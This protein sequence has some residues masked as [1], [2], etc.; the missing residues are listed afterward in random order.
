MTATL[1][2]ALQL[3]SLEGSPGLLPVKEGTA[4]VSYD[5]WTIIRV[6]DLNMLSDDLTFN[7]AKYSDLNNLIDINYNESYIKLVFSNFK[8]QLEY[9]MNQ[10]INRYK[11][12]VPSYRIKRGILNPIGSLIKIIT[13]NLDSEDAKRYDQLIENIKLKQTAVNKKVTLISEI[14]EGFSNITKAIHRNVIQLDKKLKE[15][16]NDLVNVQ[17]ETNLNF[18]SNLIIDTYSLILHNFQTISVKI[19][20]IETAVAFSK[21]ETLH[22]SIIESDDLLATLENIEKTEKL[23]FKVNQENLVKIEQSI[24]IKAFFKEN[25]LTFLLEIPLITKEVY[26]YYKLYPLPITHN[27]KTYIILPKYPYLIVKGLSSKPLAQPC[28]LIAASNFVCFEDSTSQF[29]EDTCVSDLMKYSNNTSSCTLISVIIE[30]VLVQRIQPNRWI[31][32]S[33]L[34]TLFQR[35][36]INE[37]FQQNIQGTYI[38]TLEDICE[39]KIGRFSLK[40][41]PHQIENLKYSKLPIVNLPHINNLKT[42]EMK[43]VKLEDIDL[44]SIKMAVKIM[45][46]ESEDETSEIRL[47]SVSVWTIALYLIIIIILVGI[48]YIRLKKMGFKCNFR[49]SPNPSDNFESQGGEVMRPEPHTITIRAD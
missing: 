40:L 4:V 34:K 12:L 36:C 28:Q 10:T 41:R 32:F 16:Q 15:I 23:V 35:I 33:R 20:D 22:Q 30:D 42:E 6:L 2:Q 39:V 19:N 49:N 25:Q 47:Y 14:V 13:G 3:Q 43:P 38:V 7:I 48:F 29:M 31:I 17:R 18:L 1:L 24:S 46:T 37:V 45:K 11:Q 21:L 44:D 26:M 27:L 9:I 8:S 5:K